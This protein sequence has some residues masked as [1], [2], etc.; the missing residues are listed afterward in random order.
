MDIAITDACIFIDVFLLGIEQEFFALPCRLHTTVDVLGELNPTQNEALQPFI[1]QGLLIKHNLS[2]E[3]QEQLIEIPFPKS[4]SPADRSVFLIAVEL[5]AMVLSSDKVLRN[6]AKKQKLEYHGILWVLETLV[7][8]DVLSKEDG[9]Q[10]LELLFEVN[11]T[12]AG[13]KEVLKKVGEL[14]IKWQRQI[15]N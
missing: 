3:Q 5:K 11:Q 2:S 6:W 14:V 8:S 1:G 10:K 12:M 4:L 9:L 13:S 15:K 7:N